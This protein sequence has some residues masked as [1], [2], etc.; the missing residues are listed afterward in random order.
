MQQMCYVSAIAKLLQHVASN[1]GSKVSDL[2]G[3]ANA[4]FHQLKPAQIAQKVGKHRSVITREIE[5]SGVDSRFNTMEIMGDTSENPFKNSI[6]D[7][8][9]TAICRNIEIDLRETLGETDIPKRVQAVE[10]I[11]M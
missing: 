2:V 1:T 9:L 7:V 6:N 3:P 4:V 11:L 10:N 8:P 5:R